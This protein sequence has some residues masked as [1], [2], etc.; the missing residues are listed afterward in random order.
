MTELLVELADGVLTLQ[1]N[2]PNQ[3]NALA[4]RNV[5]AL[6]HA[7]EISADDPAVRCVVLTGSGRSFCAGADVQEW[8]EADARGE[9]E[10]YGWSEAAHKMVKVISSFPKP[11]I[12]AI[13]GTAVGAGFDLALACD[14]R[15]ASKSASFRCG[16]TSMGY[17]P[18][19]GGSWLLP[20]LIGVERAK[21]LVFFNERI[22]AEEAYR[23]GLILHLTDEDQLQQTL[24]NWTD[25]LAHAPTFAL[26]RAKRLIDTANLHSLEE[27]LDLEY[28]AALECGRSSD[29]HEALQAST[30]KRAP[31]F[32]GN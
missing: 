32:R 6:R 30:E 25:R 2:R 23:I 12:A 24:C 1:L 31:S 11:T 7:L 5:E 9:L 15:I 14:F 27:Q 28:Q 22:S 10:T 16:Y 8:A 26:T 21:Q 20:R 19:M 13:N 3:R 4:R 29:A 17:S 18:D